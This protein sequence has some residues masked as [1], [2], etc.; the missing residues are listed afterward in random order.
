MSTEPTLS[1]SS[2][3]LKYWV[4]DRT[5]GRATIYLQDGQILSGAIDLEGVGES[6]VAKTIFD[7]ERWSTVNITRHGDLV[8]A[9]TYSPH[10]KDPLRGRTSVYLDQNHW[11][12]LGAAKSGSERIRSEKERAAAT[13]VADLAS[14]AGIVLPVSSA[15]LRETGALYGDRRYQ[16]G[17]TI[18]QLAGGWQLRHP[19]AVARHETLTAVSRSLQDVQTTTPLTGVSLEPY[20]CMDD[21][22]DFGAMDPDSL[23]LFLAAMSCAT[24]TL[25][26]LTDPHPTPEPSPTEWVPKHAALQSSLGTI[27]NKPARRRAAYSAAFRD[28]AGPISLALATLGLAS[29]ALDM[30]EADIPTF[31]AQMPMLGIFVE[32]YVRRLV[33]ASWTWREND[34]TDMFF[35]SCGAAYAD[36][37]VAERAT[38][39]QLK[40]VLAT[41]GRNDNVALT[42]EELVERLAQD[43][44]L[45]AS[46]RA[47]GK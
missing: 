40:Q 23:E 11:S 32:L 38:G 27:V 4:M 18:A 7:W 19:L 24:V 2:K 8:H 29:D 16:L 6:E 15:T 30:S 46:E 17:V 47:E 1:L 43:G 34:L 36:Y 31:F 26:L 35:L 42:L 14:D 5:S 44:V 25:E 13:R 9:E 39:A 37:V 28:H 20:T 10:D 41:L 3:V 45:S 12:S 21:A 22:R 33:D